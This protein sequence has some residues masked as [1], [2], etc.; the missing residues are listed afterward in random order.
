[1]DPETKSR[2]LVATIDESREQTRKI[3]DA[4]RKARTVEGLRLK[5]TRDAIRDKHHAF[6]RLLRPLDVRNPYGELL[7]CTDD[8]LLMR[9]DNPKYLALIDAVAFLHQ[10]Q[11]PV[12][13]L[14]VGDR[15]VEYIEVS[16]RDIG[17]A[18]EL[19]AE[20][21]GRSLDELNGPSRRL[22]QLIEHMVNERAQAQKVE[23]DAIVF[24][25]RELREHTR[26][27]DYQV[28]THVQQLEDLEYLVPCTGRPGQR[29]T[30]RLAW[31]GEGREG[32][33]F[34]LGLK[35]VADL[36]REAELLGIA[37]NQEGEETNQEGP[38][39]NREGAKPNRE[40]ACRAA[41][42]ALIA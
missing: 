31:H 42:P 40:G 19:A 16:L 38:L 26:W 33:P 4:Q 36:R 9:R 23:P 14:A 5:L 17:L 13:R 41:K 37:T 3:L 34:L 10:L 27:S 39:D 32:G 8:R 28:K 18:N 6:Q 29:F 25:R 12:K 30:Y 2:F 21:L 7:T 11:K 15:A 22:L 35:P 1:M 20:L 24:T